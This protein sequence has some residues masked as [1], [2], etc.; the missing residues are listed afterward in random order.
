LDSK[1]KE[2][3]AQ[4]QLDELKKALKNIDSIEI[5]D[6]N[7][8]TLSPDMFTD[9]HG[10]LS[11]TGYE[12]GQAYNN[13]VVGGGYISAGPYSATNVTF[14]Q[15]SYTL[16][17]GTG[18]NYPNTT[19]SANGWWGA[20]TATTVSGKRQLSGENADVVINGMSL[21][22]ILQDRLNVLVPNPEIESEWEELRELGEKYRALE[23]D[24]KEKAEMWNK[25][26]KKDSSPKY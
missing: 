18:I 23:K 7:T 15:P 8:I 10:A 25:L 13:T 11:M 1:E 20:N 24:L 19:I 5:E 26:K 2:Q 4:E 22:E 12:S 14:S 16:N 17:Q 6:T 21:M 9:I 3:L